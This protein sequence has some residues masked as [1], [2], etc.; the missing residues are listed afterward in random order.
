MN[1]IKDDLFTNIVL[2]E[3]FNQKMSLPFFATVDKRNTYEDF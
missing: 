1:K 2:L 3:R